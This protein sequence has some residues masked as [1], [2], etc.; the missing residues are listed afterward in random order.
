[1]TGSRDTGESGV[2]GGLAPHIPVL[3]ERVLQFMQP[4]DGATYVDGTF[5][6]GGHTRRL[7]EAA[8]C[9]V[10]G[11]DR[12]KSAIARGAGLVERA[13][14]RL[15]LV[16]DRFSALESVL[17]ALRID[18]VEGVLLDL[19]VSSMQLDE[20][21]RGFSLRADGPLDMRMGAV[22]PTAAEVVAAASLDDL[23]AIVRELGEE[24]HAR[25]VAR[26]IVKARDEAPVATTGQLAEIVRRVVRSKPGEIHPA[27]RSF[28]ALRMF[29]NEELGEIDRALHA[30][31][32]V[33]GPGGRLVVIAFH[34]LEDR[35]V[36]RFLGQRVRPL[37]VSRHAPMP[38]ERPPSF[39][40]LAAKAVA[41]D[42]AEIARNSRA[43]SAKLRAA[44]RTQA[45]AFH[46]D[47][48]GAGRLPSL[49]G[50]LRGR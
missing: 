26:A 33:L 15:I 31:E 20:P 42:A 19:G 39:R 45:P 16:E 49:E 13:G 4:R 11:I 27:T 2:A 18:Q 23:T 10:V 21:E 36:K 48:A 3:A 28:Q 1:M 9:R 12:D 47:A 6:A 7:L 30:A 37:A 32:R 38:A 14:G 46:D 34:S 41:P 44:E 8:D 24:R 29:V 17:R 25:A 40:L 35:A 5:G 50:I 43:R 22:G